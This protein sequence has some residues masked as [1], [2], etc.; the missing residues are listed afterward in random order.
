MGGRAGKTKR[1]VGEKRLVELVGRAGTY[2]LYPKSAASL[3]AVDLADAIAAGRR[4][5]LRALVVLDGTWGEAA[6]LYRR[7]CVKIEVSGGPQPA[8]VRLDG[9]GKDGDAA[10]MTVG[11]ERAVANDGARWGA[12]RRQHRSDAFSRSQLQPHHA[13][14]RGKAD[15]HRHAMPAASRPWRPCLNASGRPAPWWARRRPQRRRV[16][17]GVHSRCTSSECWCMTSER[18]CWTLRPANP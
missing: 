11:G 15:T 7:L 16:G 13:M 12:L 4:P 8:F 6:A 3:T 10:S 1:I 5:A 9:P 2:V 17:C 18:P 14:P